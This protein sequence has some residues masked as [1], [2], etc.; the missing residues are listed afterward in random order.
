MEIRRKSV[1]RTNH[2]PGSG[3]LFFQFFQRSS[4]KKGIF[5]YSGNVFFNILHP[6][7]QTDF[8]LS[9]KS[10]FLVRAILLLVENITGIRSKR[11]KKDL[12]LASGQLIFWLMETIFFSVFQ[13]LLPV[14]T[15]FRLMKTSFLMK[16]FIPASRNGFSG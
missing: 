1:L 10:I 6:L 2:T 9:G 13:R 15:F 3:H 5:P 8:L 11:S 12:I 7:V 16:S 14:M 4:K